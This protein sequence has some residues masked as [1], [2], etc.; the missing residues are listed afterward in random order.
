MYLS[1]EYQRRCREWSDIYEHLPALFQ[2]V[3]TAPAAPVIVE[4][5]TRSGNSTSAFLHGCQI[6][7]GG[8]VHSVDI[9]MPQVPGDWWDVPF[10][11]FHQGSST[12]QDVLDKLPMEIDVLF[13]D[14]S[15]TYD[16][17]LSELTH[18]LPR[19][20]PG[21]VAFFHD[22][23]VMNDV[24]DVAK[25]LDEYCGHAGLRWTNDPR[26]YGLGRIQ[27]PVKR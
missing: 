7:K 22:T 10:W 5:G 20:K 8:V 17:T 2:A 4:L 21:G 9:E 6:N 13:V 12:D 25:A 19:V 24:C 15:H 14:T 27:V 23:E 3:M 18:Y 11:F 16:Q 26:C 1:D